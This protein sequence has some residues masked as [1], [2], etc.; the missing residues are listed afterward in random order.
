M[1]EHMKPSPTVPAPAGRCPQLHAGIVLAL[2]PALVL[3]QTAQ[4][5]SPSDPSAAPGEPPATPPATTQPANL[6][7][8]SV[9]LDT[10]TRTEDAGTYISDHDDV[11]A[12]LVTGTGSLVL[13]SPKISTTGSAAANVS[14]SSGL[15]SAVVA[16]DGGHISIAG[17]SIVTSGLG[18]NGVF[19]GGRTSMIDL[20]ELSIGTTGDGSLGVVANS[21]G[22][23]VLHNVDIRTG[24]ANSPALAIEQDG[25]SIV[26]T[27]G[28]LLAEG[29]EAPALY[30]QG[31][32]NLSGTTAKTDRA[33]AVVIENSGSLSMKGG[34]LLGTR[35]C[36]ALIFRSGSTESRGRHGA[37]SME[38]G[39][40]SALGGPL[41]LVTNAHCTIRLSGVTL[42]APSGVLIEAMADRWGRKG[43]NGGHVMFFA[44]RQVLIGDLLCDRN[45]S[46]GAT[47]RQNSVLV[48][49]LD[50][51]GLTLD[52]TSKWEVS[53]DSFVTG[54]TIAQNTVIDGVITCIV[55][56]GH[57]ITYDSGNPANRWLV[58]KDYDLVR[59]GRL[60]P[61]ERPLLKR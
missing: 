4:V 44:D 6:L 14:H 49:K 60:V 17:G 8:G 48:G 54:L 2:L 53:G 25:G 41:F 28:S 55:G 59:G 39:T 38:G 20:K 51:V 45:S 26:A 57:T 58:N 27:G 52:G 32:V 23:V 30:T 61:L 1:A 9:T 12:I 13:S 11:S 15:N 18:A 21:G 33:S 7:N 22:T 50:H 40:F 5:A 37:F 56:H 24:G 3:A 16:A 47:L 42:E 31:T 29:D 19:A 43:R 34:S 35:L 10:G 36:G 46:I